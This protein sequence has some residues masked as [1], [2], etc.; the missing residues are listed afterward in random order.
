MTPAL[1]LR[2]PAGDTI[3]RFADI[4]P[5]ALIWYPP[6]RWQAGETVRITTLPLYLPRDWG[7]VIDKTPGLQIAADRTIVGGAGVILVA[8]YQR[9][10][11]DRLTRL[12]A[13]LFRA[14]N[15]AAYLIAAGEGPLTSTQGIFGVGH[16]ALT[17]HAWMLAQA[18][19][20]GEVV[21]L[22]L[23]WQ[24]A[25]STWPAGATVFVHLRQAGNNRVQADG[26][27]RYFVNYPL[28]QQLAHQGYANDWRQLTVPADAVPSS[29]SWQVVI[30]LYDVKSGRRFAVVS[31]SGQPLGD[32]LVVGTWPMKSKP[33]PDQTCALIPETC[34]AQP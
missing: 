17:V 31:P 33:V 22:W 23:H 4:M 12:P 30:G 29:D 5:P 32:E 9:G 6:I 27:P 1:E 26:L 15:P 16:S 25:A 13:D 3:Y 2:T 28:A 11:H 19:W 7:I 34:A 10:Q 8:A 20:P 24:T 21:N 14:E 18:I